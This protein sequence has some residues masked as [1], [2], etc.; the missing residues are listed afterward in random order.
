MGR[1]RDSSEPPAS[2]WLPEYSRSPS[3]AGE[4]RAGP[5]AAASPSTAT[6]TVLHGGCPAGLPQAAL[7]TRALG[8]RPWRRGAAERPHGEQARWL[9]G[10]QGCCVL[11]SCSGSGPRVRCRQSLQPVLV[12]AEPGLT[13]PSGWHRQPLV[14]QHRALGPGPSG[15]VGGRWPGSGA[16]IKCRPVAGWSRE[17]SGVSR[18]GPRGAAKLGSRGQRRLQG[19][20]ATNTTPPA[21]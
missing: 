3:A 7:S 10:A 8:R 19:A 4:N 15:L 18:V 6:R 14:P 11:L 1:S 12:L 20:R 21:M 16:R 2:R 13:T 5:T 17:E 9:H